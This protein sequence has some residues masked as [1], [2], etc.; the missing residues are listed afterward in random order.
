[1]KHD[2]DKMTKAELR[3]YVVAHPNDQ[4]AFHAFVDRFTQDAP[5]ELFP[6]VTSEAEIQEVAK[7]VQQKVEQTRM[8]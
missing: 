4:G 3:A 8:T 7:L 2:F 1:M 5:Q 6:P